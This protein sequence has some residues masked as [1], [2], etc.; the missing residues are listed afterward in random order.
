MDSQATLKKEL[1]VIRKK[2]QLK[3]KHFQQIS[4]EK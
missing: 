3:G 4:H 2:E 1:F